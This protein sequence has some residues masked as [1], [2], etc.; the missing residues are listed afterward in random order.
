MI[1]EL[2]E[3]EWS[4]TAG[5]PVYL[6]FT[7]LPISKTLVRANGEVTVDLDA[8]NEVVG[9]EMLS[10]DPEEWVAVA[11]IGKEHSLRFDLFLAGA[12]KR[13]GVA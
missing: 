6:R 12:K 8:Y 4:G 2:D 1:R 3:I 5:D 10:T 7:K 9:I 13:K 11:E